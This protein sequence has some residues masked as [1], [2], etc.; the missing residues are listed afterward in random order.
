M[1]KRAD[2]FLVEFKK[3]YG[4]SL[5]TYTYTLNL[6]NNLKNFFT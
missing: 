2:S 4:N 6:L 5:R 3:E 1:R